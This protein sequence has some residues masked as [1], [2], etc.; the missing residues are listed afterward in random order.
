VSEVRETQAQAI[1]MEP[2][3]GPA[4]LSLQFKVPVP[5]CK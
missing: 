4:L 1:P 5:E 2:K 3:E